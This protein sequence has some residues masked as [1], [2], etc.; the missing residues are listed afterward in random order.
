MSLN[1]ALSGLLTA[2]IS[3]I[4]IL[5][6]VYIRLSRELQDRKDSGDWRNNPWEITEYK[7]AKFL[8]WSVYTG[9]VA[10]L[11]NLLAWG[12][13]LDIRPTSE[14]E[15]GV[16]LTVVVGVLV[17]IEVIAILAGIKYSDDIV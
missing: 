13:L 7:I 10:C 3:S 11:I 1:T 2:S 14:F 16:T 17:M 9:G 8:K 12:L 15:I 4:S 5:T 6:F